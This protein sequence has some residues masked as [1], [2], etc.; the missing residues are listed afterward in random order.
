MTHE[1]IITPRAEQEAQ[2]NR[3]GWAAN[4]SADHADR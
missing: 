4:R 1:V 3:D 2:A